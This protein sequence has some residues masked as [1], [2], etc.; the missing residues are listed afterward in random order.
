MRATLFESILLLS[1]V[2][3]TMAVRPM[4]YMSF[5]MGLVKRQATCIGPVI[6]EQTASGYAGTPA[7]TETQICPTEAPICT[8]SDGIP[9]CSGSIGDWLTISRGLNTLPATD[10]PATSTPS[11]ETSTPVET[12]TSATETSTSFEESFTSEPTIESSTDEPTS[13]P[14]S[15]T[16]ASETAAT[17]SSRGS[18]TTTAATT[19]SPNSGVRN[20]LG[21]GCIASLFLFTVFLL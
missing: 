21:L 14:A 7:P 1:T 15:T 13:T 2:G 9:V 19:A 10:V 16:D 20:Q 18:S 11:F 6:C 12:P 4:A 17:T 5:P 8:A 3:V